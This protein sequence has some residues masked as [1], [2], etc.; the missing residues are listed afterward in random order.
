MAVPISEF[1]VVSKQLEVA[2]QR[3]NELVL[4][5]S[6][7][8][9][10][11]ADCQKKLRD[12]MEAEEQLKYL[13]EVKDEVEEEHEIVKK[14]LEAFDP[15]F[16]WEN[17][18][19][20]KIAL[21]IKRAKISPLQ[22]FEEFDRSK[23]GHLQRSEF[24]QALE[25]LKI[26]DLTAQ[27]LDVLWSSF[28]SDRSGSINYKEFSRKLERYGVRNRSRE[29]T[30]IYQMIDAVQRSKVKSLN[31][32]FELIDKSG[33]G[34]ISRDDFSDIFQ[35]LNLRIDQQE[36][37]K[38]MDNF[39]K[40][41]DA[42]IDYQ[43]F[44]RIFGRYQVR[45]NKEQN[46][47]SGPKVATDETVRKKKSIYDQISKA[48][49]ETGRTLP[50]LFRKIDTDQ[51][52]NIG[53]EELFKMFKQMQLDVTSQQSIAIFDTIDFDGNGQISLPEFV[54]D[55]KMVCATSIEELIRE[56]HQ[57]AQ[58]N[59]KASL[60]GAASGGVPKSVMNEIQ[61]QTRIDIM[62]ARERQL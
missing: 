28:D 19:F 15:V 20:S 1:Q 55:F 8:V 36:L 17:Q 38:F 32:L 43:G 49:N 46:A 2:K 39:W 52:R 54:S 53:S 27:E 26:Y 51:S 10:Q 21:I 48:L 50:E 60:A 59:E 41:K 47:A 29:E 22:A 33:R 23:D 35:S 16:R 4:R 40:D 14:R 24:I 45:M 3:Q 37:D 61:A 57:K 18:V 44:L 9:K 42:G 11:I 6:K 7:L 56:E 58:N 25:M 5:N 31:G 62:Q 34:F 12:N 30:I 13:Q